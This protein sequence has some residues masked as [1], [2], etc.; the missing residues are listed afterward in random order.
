MKFYIIFDFDQE[1]F[2]IVFCCSLFHIHV[3]Y[4]YGD[5]FMRV[6]LLFIENILKMNCDD[7]MYVT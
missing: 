5:A 7:Y 4:R 3:V 1:Q 2:N 6:H